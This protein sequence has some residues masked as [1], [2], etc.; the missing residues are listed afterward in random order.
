MGCLVWGGG[1]V[2]WLMGWWVAWWML[3]VRAKLVSC[4]VTCLVI[5]LY[6][7]CLSVVWCVGFDDFGCL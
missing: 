7:F 5:V 3:V 2:F 4:F 1:F 6:S